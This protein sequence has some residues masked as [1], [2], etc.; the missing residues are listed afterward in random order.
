MKYRITDSLVPRRSRLCQAW[1]LLLSMGPRVSR[2][3]TKKNRT[4]ATSRERQK[5][6]R[7]QISKMTI[8]H[9]PH[10]F[11]YI[12]LPSLHDNDVD[13]NIALRPDSAPGE[14]AYISKWVGTIAVKTENANWPFKG[15]FRR[16]RRPRLWGPKRLAEKGVALSRSLLHRIRAENEARESGGTETRLPCWLQKVHSKVACN[17]P[18]FAIKTSTLHSANSTFPV[19]GESGWPFSLSKNQSDR[20]LQQLSGPYRMFLILC[21]SNVIEEFLNPDYVKLALLTN[22]HS[23]NYGA[24]V[25]EQIFSF[26]VWNNLSPDFQEATNLTSSSYF[27]QVTHPSK[28]PHSIQSK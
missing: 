10:F 17:F 20:G 2:K 1:T 18:I 15:R 28:S 21:T 5:S 26:N 14:L 24:W 19:F 16:C 4:A 22:L 7:S 6:N 12:F 9:A 3:G 23:I 13:L 25:L 11:L 27:K 8:L